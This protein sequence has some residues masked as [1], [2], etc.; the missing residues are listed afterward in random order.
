[1]NET[2]YFILGI[3]C[4]IT[5]VVLIAAGFFYVGIQKRKIK[6]QWEI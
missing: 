2:I 5:G 3:G 6:E 1:M 4:I